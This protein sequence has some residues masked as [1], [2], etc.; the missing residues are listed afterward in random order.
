MHRQ[1]A[2]DPPGLVVDHSDGNGLNNQKY[3]LRNCTQQKNTFNR[4]ATG[5][6]SSFKGV[7]AK[8]EKWIAQITVDGK[9]KYL[10][11]FDSEIDA[12]LAYDKEAWKLHGEFALTNFEI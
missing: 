9:T 4:P 6:T 7:S 11:A 5:K 3:N 2:G 10:G 12:A 1:I 8:G